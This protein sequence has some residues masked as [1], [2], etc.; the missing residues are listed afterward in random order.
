MFTQ[1]VSPPAGG[2]STQRSNEA[3]DGV[4]RQ[5]TSVWKM[6]SLALLAAV[7]PSSTSSV[8]GVVGE[9][10]M[11]LELTEPAGEVDVR[12]GRDVLVAE[13]EDLVANQRLAQGCD[14]V[15]VEGMVEVDRGHLGADVRRDRREVEVGVAP[16]GRRGAE[17]R[18]RWAWVSWSV[19][20]VDPII[21]A[22]WA[23]CPVHF[24]HH[25]H[26]HMA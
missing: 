11:H 21:R 1:I 10:G 24:D 22:R 14:G 3:I 7:P 2:H 18:G 13:H 12:L 4:C 6:F 17:G 26:A 5:D 19:R 15:V 20:M 8:V 9:D 25:L 23:M 16:D